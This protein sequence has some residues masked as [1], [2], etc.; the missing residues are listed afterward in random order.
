MAGSP[1]LGHPK[2]GVLALQGS[3]REHIRSLESTGAFA[4]S[5]KKPEHLQGI[6]GLV[7]PGGES[8]TIVKLAVMYDLLEPL[9]QLSASGFPLFGSCAGMIL[10]ADRIEDGIEGQQTIG[11]I[12]ATIKRNAFGR[13]TESFEAGVR[14]ESFGEVE[15]FRG[16]FIRAPWVVEH[17]AGVTPF[18]SISEG[19]HAGRIVG[20]QEGN[21]LATAFH[22]ELTPDNRIHELFVEI[23]RKA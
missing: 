20:L 21:L 11:G 7:I 19:E 17:G 22:P 23:V 18:C 1:T 4:V 15:P 12:D 3:V 5:V 14:V 9:R 2:I 6:D 16:V 10:L 8:T 13:Q